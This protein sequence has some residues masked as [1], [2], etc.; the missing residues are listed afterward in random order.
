MTEQNILFSKCRGELCS[1][2]FCY[3]MVSVMRANTV[4]HYIARRKGIDL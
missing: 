1:P 4:R 2:E 3:C